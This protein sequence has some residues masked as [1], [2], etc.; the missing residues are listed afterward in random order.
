MDVITSPCPNLNQFMLVKGNSDDE[1]V[2][3]WGIIPAPPVGGVVP[4]HLMSWFLESPGHQQPCY[5]VYEINKSL[6]LMTKNS[7]RMP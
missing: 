7:H 3:T 1:D 2:T 5:L 6:I 4:W